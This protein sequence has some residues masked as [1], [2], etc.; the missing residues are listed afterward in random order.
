MPDSG[1]ML[2]CAH[3]LHAASSDVGVCLPATQA[4]HSASADALPW[5]ALQTHFSPMTQPCRTSAGEHVFGVLGSTRQIS[6]DLAPGS[7]VFFCN[8]GRAVSHA[9]RG[10][11]LSITVVD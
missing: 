1:A 4:S 9:A 11:V 8:L 2:P 7:Y 3:G 10:Q 5:P 6:F